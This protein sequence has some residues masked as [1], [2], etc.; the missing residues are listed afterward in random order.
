MQENGSCPDS[1]ARGKEMGLHGFQFPLHVVVASANVLG[2]QR[3]PASN[4]NN[5]VTEKP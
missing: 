5:P 4:G 1:R 2:A 3:L